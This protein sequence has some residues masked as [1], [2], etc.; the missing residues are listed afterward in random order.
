MDRRRVAAGQAARLLRRPARPPLGRR[1]GRRARRRGWP[2]A[3]RPTFKT[4][5]TCAAEF[6]AETP[7]H[8]STYED[9]DEVRPS[10]RPKVVILG[11]G[12]N[13]IGQGIEFDYC[14]VHASF[15]LRDAGYETVMVNCNPE[16]VSTDYDTSDRLYFE[17]L[18]EEDVLNVL[19]AETARRS[20]SV[21]APRAARRRS[22]WPARCPRDL[23]AGTSP[24]VHRPG[25]GPRALERSCAP[26][27]RSRSR[28]AA[29]PPPLERGA[30]RHRP[31]R[32]PGARA[33]RATC[34]AAGPC[35]SCYD[36]GRRS[37]DAMAGAG[38]LRRL[39]RAR[40]AGCRPSGPVLID[41]FL[42]DAVEVDV[43]AIRDATG[44]VLIGGVMEHVEEAG[45]HS[46]RLAPAPSRRPRCC[47]G[48]SRSSR[49][50]P[51][52][53]PTPSTCGASSTCSTRC[54]PEPGVRHR[55]QPPGQPHGALRGQGHRRAAGQG[56]GPGHARAPR[57]P[58][59][60][61]RACC[62]R[63]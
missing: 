61:T 2:P 9:E 8:Y 1:R 55:G 14:C 24:D 49:P 15:A 30:G 7:Y 28:P 4:V 21:V 50:T 43:D 36:A 46:R 35:R 44:E 52:P 59:C 17:P 60:A 63:P 54:R 34:S 27:S 31:G 32:L 19:D 13:R 39:A 37:K 48:S 57:W 6:E 25:R 42:E 62:G 20:P 26:T 56:G 10:D 3:S 38:R 18:T 22:S 29:P 53:S 45:V 40:R 11:S 33:A 16:T 47:R 12:P 5:D 41:R 51:G 58:S 23:I